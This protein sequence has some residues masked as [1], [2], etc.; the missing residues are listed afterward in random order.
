MIS[1]HHHD[2]LAYDFSTSI[3]K[4]DRHEHNDDTHH[5]HDSNGADNHEKNT[6]KDHNHSFPLHNHVCAEN[7]F[8]FTGTNIQKSK[9]SNYSIKIFSVLCLFLRE[10][11]EPPNRTNYVC[12]DPPFL[13]N[14]LFEPGAIALRGPPSIV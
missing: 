3:K 4:V 8:D 2:S 12:T 1:H 10:Y 7:D 14:S 5:H 6:D 9:T 13:I 11:S